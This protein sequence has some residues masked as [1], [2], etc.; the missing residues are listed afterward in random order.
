[1]AWPRC[2][3]IFFLTPVPAYK[4]EIFFFIVLRLTYTQG[5]ILKLSRSF[6]IVVPLCNYNKDISP[7]FYFVHL[8]LA[9]SFLVC[10]AR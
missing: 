8:Q 1:M 3:S 9:A 10:G 2:Y 5:L 4:M 6:L 7:L